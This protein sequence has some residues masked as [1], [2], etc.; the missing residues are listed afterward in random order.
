MHYAMDLVY[1]MK[2]LGADRLPECYLEQSPETREAPQKRRHPV[3]R[4]Q[5]MGIGQRRRHGPE[6]SVGTA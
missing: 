5:G 4:R 1:R 2:L 6:K 3:K